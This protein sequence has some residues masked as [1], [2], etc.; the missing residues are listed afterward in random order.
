MKKWIVALGILTLIWACSHSEGSDNGNG[1][2]SES[3]AANTPKKPDGEKIYRN[4]CVTCHGLYGDMGA[5]GAFNLTTSELSM[6]E[7][8]GVITNG[9][10]AMPGFKAILNEEKIKAVAE[11]TLELKK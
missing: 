11:Y 8:I 7:R 10:N 3:V 1:G 5:S 9:R 2:S 4:S 6:E